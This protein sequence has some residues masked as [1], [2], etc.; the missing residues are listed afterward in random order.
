MGV[1]EEEILAQLREIFRGELADQVRLL[2]QQRVV[3]LRSQSTDAERQE[4]VFE[5]YR[6][7]HSLKGAARSVG[8]E[9]IVELCHGFEDALGDA[10][11]GKVV[12]LELARRVVEAALTALEGFVDPEADTRDPVASPQAEHSGETMRVSVAQ[13]ARLMRACDNLVGL[14]GETPSG[15]DFEAALGLIRQG[16]RNLNAM[17][18]TSRP[19]VDA[20]SESLRMCSSLSRAWTIQQTKEAIVQAQ[21]RR[22][23]VEV[24]SQVRALRLLTAQDLCVSLEKAATEHAAEL[25]KSVHYECHGA[26]LRLDREI[27]GRIRSPLLHLVHNAIDH[28]LEHPRDRSNVGKPPQ[29]RLSLDIRIIGSE[30]RFTLEDDGRG[31]DLEALTRQA[32]FRELIPTDGT[33]SDDEMAELAFLPGLSTHPVATETSGRGVGLDV[34]RQRVQELQ[35]RIALST[36]RGEGSRVEL[37]IPT[38]VNAIVALALLCDHAEY[39]LPIVAV[40]R[41]LR[42][43][44][45]Q[46]R[47]IEGGRWLVSEEE[48]VVPLSPLSELLG[49]GATVH[50]GPCIILV[51]GARKIALQVDRVLD[52]REAVT[53]PLGPRAL[54]SPFVA[55]ASLSADGCVL[56]VL[57]IEELLRQAR[58]G[59]PAGGEDRL[60]RRRLLVVDD[61]ITTRQLVRTILEAAGHEVALAEDGEAAWRAILH[62]GPF[63]LVVSDIEM[64]ALNGLQL[65][66]RVRGSRST[67]TLPFVLVTALESDDDRRRAMDLGA[68]AY[69]VKSSFDQQTLL[70]TVTDLLP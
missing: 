16:L 60:Q 70:D 5:I 68:D 4:A 35:G 32:R 47:T 63:D 61:S 6:A 64:P 40:E 50:D 21:L 46:V 31:F 34:V 2:Q 65:L 15:T 52:V 59:A 1:G 8:E 55:S 22:Q 33:Y 10:R 38:Q 54:G 20:I 17:G 36:R 25:G 66:A 42:P 29:G 27:L 24:S 41:V 43:H 13:V 23:V 18:P 69:V 26:D 28:G 39:L 12:D 51:H 67:A 49:T 14:V 37:W 62:R 57:D 45:K 9:R 19:Y 58:P 11:H 3:L 30:V 53:R 56:P 44:S 48:K 7:V